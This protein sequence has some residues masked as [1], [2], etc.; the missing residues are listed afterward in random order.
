MQRDEDNIEC[1]TF[2]HVE[3][4]QK[5]YQSFIRP[6]NIPNERPLLYQHLDRTSN[7]QRSQAH[8]ERPRSLDR[9]YTSTSQQKRSSSRAQ[10]IEAKKRISSLYNKTKNIP[11]TDGI[12]TESDSP[13]PTPEK[14]KPIFSS[15]SD[16]L[17]DKTNDNETNYDSDKS[18][19]QWDY[20]DL[21]QHPDIDDV[22][23]QQPLDD[24]F[25]NPPLN[26]IATD[27]NVHTNRVYDFTQLLTTLSGHSNVEYDHQKKGDANH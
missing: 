6:Q 22:F 23:P 19:D 13:E 24:S 3:N 4:H 5:E 14:R 18:Y 21:H 12:N 16:N 25:M 11:Q 10:S 2:E 9:L 27:T 26:L 15:T 20:S 8:R 17:L 1:A 7:N